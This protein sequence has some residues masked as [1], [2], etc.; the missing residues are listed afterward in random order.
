MPNYLLET[1]GPLRFRFNSLG[2]LVCRA[3][4]L[5]NPDAYV[6]PVPAPAEVPPWVRSTVLTTQD[7]PGTFFDINDDEGDLPFLLGEGIVQQTGA[8][9]LV[10]SGLVGASPDGFWKLGDKSLADCLR[11]GMGLHVFAKMHKPSHS[12]AIAGMR[13]VGWAKEDFTAFFM[14]GLNGPNWELQTLVNGSLRFTTL[15]SAATAVPRFLHGFLA[16]SGTAHSKPSLQSYTLDPNAYAGGDTQTM[17]GGVAS[18][19]AANQDPLADWVAAIGDGSDWFPTIR[20]DG[21]DAAD[22]PW[23]IGEAHM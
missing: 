2:E 22:D 20:I 18:A 7:G 10:P 9:L 15:G 14:V 11:M 19:I 1:S 6:P 13:L 4:G 3:L 12:A 21:Y 16:P 8:G 17:V 5:Q 23:A